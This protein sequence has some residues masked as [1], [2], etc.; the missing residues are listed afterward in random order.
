MRRSDSFVIAAV[1]L[2]ST[3]HWIGG[4]VALLI[5]LVFAEQ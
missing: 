3:G 4:S 2:Y 1:A 5:A